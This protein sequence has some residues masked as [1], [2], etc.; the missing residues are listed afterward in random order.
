MSLTL[1]FFT[2]PS[3]NERTF[4]V[5]AG[6]GP[7]QGDSTTGEAAAPGLQAREMKPL[8]LCQLE[9]ASIIFLTK[10]SL[11]KTMLLNLPSLLFPSDKPPASH[12]D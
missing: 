7:T 10:D 5:L 12:K 2:D 9:S 8:E 11:G 6:E 4:Q 1:K 3:S